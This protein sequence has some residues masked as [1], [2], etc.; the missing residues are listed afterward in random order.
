M[1]NDMKIKAIKESIEEIVKEYLFSISSLKN[2]NYFKQSKSND[3]R[4]KYYEHTG[5]DILYSSIENEFVVKEENFLEG[6]TR[7]FLINPI[8]KSLLDIYEIDNDWKFGDTFA[9]FSISNREYELGNFIEFIAVLNG[10]KVG[11]RYT[12]ASYSLEE[13]ATMDRDFKFLYNNENIPGFDVLKTVNK[14]YV[15]NW[16]GLSDGELNEINK[17]ISNMRSVKKDISIEKFFSQYFTKEIFDIVI[18][19]AKEAVKKA[20]D[21]ISLSAV[22]QLLPNNMLNFKQSILEKFSFER[23]EKLTYEFQNGNSVNGLT[24]TDILAMNKNFFDL[25][26]RQA[27]VGKED[28][29]RSFIT[30]EYLFATV[31]EGLSIDYTSVV[32]GYL[33]SVEQLLYLLYISAFEGK[34]KMIYWDR[35]NKSQ[36]FDITKPDKYRY[37]PYNIQNGWMQEK[38]WHK[39]KTGDN[40]PEIGELTRFLR[41]YD[42]M[43]VVSETGK[44]FIYECLEDFRESCRNSHFHKDNIDASQYDTVKR[45]RNNTHLCLYFLLSGFKL[46]DPSVSVVKQLGVIDYKFELFYQDIRQ[47]R[48]RFF[49]IKSVVD[50]EENILCY[51]NDDINIHFNE[52]GMLVD[53]Q[54]KFMKIDVDRNN[55]YVDEIVRLMEDRRYVEENTIWIN[56]E[57]MPQKIEAILPKKRK[58]SF[59]RSCNE[60]AGR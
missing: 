1:S 15:L 12:R 10:E 21:I 2:H 16:T 17:T 50:G 24:E 57:N 44:E 4:K 14:V 37:D 48:R 31:K 35:C 7:V 13:T 60:N 28:F 53:S 19:T 42:E 36:Y 29:A 45:I 34:S 9:N 3:T 52:A 6:C 54:L 5:F 56:R 11:I 39:K 43:W 22:P 59:E 18:T 46:L 58:T 47:K 49:A 33:K 55:I 32:V 38:Y 30:S 23:M 51:L 41:Y 25:E 20:K 40:A 8:M 27:L 26:Y